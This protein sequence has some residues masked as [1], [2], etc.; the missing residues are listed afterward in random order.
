MTRVL[1]AGGGIAGLTLAYWL[2]RYGIEAVVVERAAGIRREGYAIDFFG[3]GFD[4]A[5]RMGIADALKAKQV[6]V[7]RLVYVDETGKTIAVLAIDRMRAMLGGKYAALMH[8]ALEQTL[9]ESVERNVEVRFGQSISAIA[10]MPNGI[11]VDF[12]DGHHDRFDLVVGADGLHSA[13]RETVLGL[14]RN[15]LRPLGYAVATYRVPNRYDLGRTWAML[16]APGR[17]IG[18]YTS[19][20]PASLFAFFFYRTTDSAHV[21]RAERLACLQHEFSNIGWIAG[22]LLRDGPPGE[23]IFMDAV[24]QIRMPSWSRGRIAFVGDACGCPTLVSGQGASLAMGGAYLLAHHLHESA[25]YRTAFERYESFFRP[26]VEAQ[27]R[28]AVRFT[29]Q[30]AP[31]T[32]FGVALQRLLLRV[33]FRDPFIGLM[34]G[35]F[36]GR[37]ALASSLG[38]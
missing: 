16:T 11:D 29:R 20:D 18:V 37:S 23:G 6:P 27:Q 8:H 10:E 38:S 35:M 4:V 2:D 17:I 33:L 19:D 13:L 7:D 30:F 3:T 32:W 22:D 31:N 9:F 36:D 5:E 24:A 14:E 26:N 28:S 21:P 25:D 15:V 12:E 34:R 1:V